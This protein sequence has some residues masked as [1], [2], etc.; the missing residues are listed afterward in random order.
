MRG[1]NLTFTKIVQE[2]ARKILE[3]SH[4]K[5]VKMHEFSS[6]GVNI[7]KFSANSAKFCAVTRPCDRDI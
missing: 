7:S 3:K 2:N 5:I 1:Q 6:L 4:V